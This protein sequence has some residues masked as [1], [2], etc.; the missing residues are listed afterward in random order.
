M[1]YSKYL[2]QI[3]SIHFEGFN[4]EQNKDLFYLLPCPS[5]LSLKV[6]LQEKMA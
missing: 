6:L 5:K 2:N 3:E 1:N 4:G